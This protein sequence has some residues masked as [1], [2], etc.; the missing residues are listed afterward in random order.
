ML[1]NPWVSLRSPTALELHPFGMKP[2]LRALQTTASE[3]SPDQRRVV[4]PHNA[5][6]KL[7]VKS[8]NDQTEL[9]GYESNCEADNLDT[10]I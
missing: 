1:T 5:V 4:D 9:M 6:L 3:E 10:A 7:I 2:R 8:N